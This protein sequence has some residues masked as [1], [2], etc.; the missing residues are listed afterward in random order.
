MVQ[1]ILCT[2][3]LYQCGYGVD[4][5]LY[6]IIAT[7][8]AHIVLLPK[9]RVGPY[10][11]YQQ[12]DSQTQPVVLCSTLLSHIMK[13]AFCILCFSYQQQIKSMIT[14]HQFLLIS[15]PPAKEAAFQQAKQR[16]G[17]TYAFQ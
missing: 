10:T 9:A 12:R 16:H 17:S 7:C 1:L 15:S 5:V 4:T 13:L 2:L 11:Q 8:R 14:K 6:R 3:V